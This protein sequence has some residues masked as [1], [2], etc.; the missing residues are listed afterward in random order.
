MRNAPA[1]TDQRAD[2]HRNPD[3]QTDQVP[4][5]K[6]SKR[7]KEIIS[8]HCS[9][10]ANP[11][12]LR[13]IGRQYL[14]LNDDREYRSN[15]RAPQYRKQTSTSVFN[16]SSVLGVSAASDFQNFSACNAFGIREVRSRDQSAPQRNR[17]HHAQNSSECADPKRSPERKLSPIADH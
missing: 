17:I 8:A 16:V 4:D 1:P 13:H 10:P 3:G 5:P 11:K 6:K 9:A 15:D 7:Q 2:K 14:R 12:S